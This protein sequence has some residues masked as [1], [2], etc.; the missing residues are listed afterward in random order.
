MSIFAWAK[1]PATKSQSTFIGCNQ[2]PLR[3]PRPLLALANI[4]MYRLASLLGAILAVWLTVWCA[5]VNKARGG[6]CFRC[7]DGGHVAVGG[8]ATL[9]TTDAVLL[10]CEL[11]MQRCAAAGLV[12]RAQCRCI[13][14]FNTFG[15]VGLGCTGCWHSG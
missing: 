3:Q 12:R 11:G 10:A 13:G 8:E 1:S 4:W 6:I 14:A 9:A 15:V 7:T 2:L 5:R